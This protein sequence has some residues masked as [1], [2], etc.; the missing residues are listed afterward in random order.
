MKPT[1]MRDQRWCEGATDLVE[2]VQLGLAQL[3]N[4]WGQRYHREI[5]LGGM[6]DLT[7]ILV[8]NDDR[9]TGC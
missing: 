9:F 4:I 8:Y 3:S 5:P 2:I 1:T 7:C 6:C